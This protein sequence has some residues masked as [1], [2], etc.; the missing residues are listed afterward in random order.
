MKVLGV[1]NTHIHIVR[2]GFHLLFFNRCIVGRMIGYV[3][4]VCCVS[5]MWW[6]E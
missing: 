3:K 1:G 6:W 5:M 2:V 4:K